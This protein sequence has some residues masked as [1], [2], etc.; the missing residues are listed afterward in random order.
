[1]NRDKILVINC[2]TSSIKFT[3]FSDPN[4]EAI[5]DGELCELF[6]ENCRLKIKNDDSFLSIPDL[7]TYSQGVEIV[8]QQMEKRHFKINEIKKVGHRIVHGADLFQHPVK[9][10]QHVLDQLKDISELAPLHNPPSLEAIESIGKFLGENVSQYAVFDTTFHLNKK[11]EASLYA[12]PYELSEK[13]RIKRYGF[14]GISHQ[15]M[16][17]SFVQI[18]PL[19]H[20]NKK[21]ITLHLG[22]GS[23]LAAVS[24]GVSVDT[25]MGFTPLEGVMMGKRSGS[26]DPTIVTFLAEKENKEPQKILEI[27]NEQSGLLGV[28]AQSSDMKVLLSL[29]NSNSKAKIAVNMYIYQIVKAIG[30]MSAALEG[31]DAIIFSGGIGENARFIRDKIIHH[32]KWLDVHL[33]HEANNSKN[34]FIDGVKLISEKHSKAKIYIV[35][36]DE[37]LE[38]AKHILA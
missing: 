5:L 1:M 24:K 23:S 31:F 27:L 36:A 32:L 12:I 21:I 4:L 26:I 11:L 16:W 28:S 8:F 10:D 3:L 13:Y 7:K 20:Q 37:N 38:I 2:G 6:T 19:E 18:N 17:N 14:H 30:S 33:D 15:H 25:T 34:G 9:I 22:S 35:K 29:Q